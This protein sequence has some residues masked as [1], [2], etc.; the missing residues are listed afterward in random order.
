MRRIHRLMKGMVLVTID[1]KV[2]CA[3]TLM[4]YFPACQF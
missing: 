2:L 4:A 3:D 1:Y